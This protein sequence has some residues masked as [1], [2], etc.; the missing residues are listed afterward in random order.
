MTTVRSAGIALLVVA[1][2]AGSGDTVTVSAASSLTDAFR[3]IETAYEADHPD[4]DIVVNF[5]GSAT[6]REQI[7]GGAPVD[8][9]A[10]ADSAT[11]EDVVAAGATAGSPVVFARNR[12]QI[13]VPKGNPAGV[14]GLDDFADPGLLIGLCSA[15]VPCGDLARRAL[16]LAGVTAAV[17]T[18]EPD[19][20]ALLTKIEAGELDAG[21][22]YASD[23]VARADR[24]DGIE[25][26]PAA[27]V[28]TVYPI[29]LIGDG[30]DAAAGFIGYVT[31]PAGRDILTRYG[32]QQP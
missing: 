30:D 14:R 32:F 12:L 2:A 19:V 24:V 28:E 10:A 23:V 20:R 27:Q 21:L 17:D 4:V 5:S 6:L 15:G 7:L 1:C 13:A 9:F 11:M 29:V 31:S 22:V 18:N 3:E 26:D 25:L 8:V 16:Q